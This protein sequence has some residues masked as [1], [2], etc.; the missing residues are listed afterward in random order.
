M[1]RFFA[2]SNPEVALR[3]VAA[4]FGLLGAFFVLW[5]LLK[6]SD[7]DLAPVR[8]MVFGFG[9]AHGL[10]SVLLLRASE[11]GRRLGFLLLGIWALIAGLALVV[12]VGFSLFWNHSVP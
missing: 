11:W 7:L 3:V 8:L 12:D 2:P 6:L 4:L 5:S 10:A 9:I 1:R